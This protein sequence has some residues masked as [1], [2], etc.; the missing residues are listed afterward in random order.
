MLT[1]R[2]TIDDV[3]LCRPRRFSDARGWFMETYSRATHAA[4]GIRT[5][6]I[7]DN[8]SLSKLPFT[9]RGLHFQT[10]PHVQAKLVRVVRGS[11]FDVAVDLRSGSQ[12]Y[13][14][15]CGAT[16]TAEGGEQLFIPAGF[17]H[18]FCTLEPDTEVCYKV[19]GLYAPECDQGLRWDDP[20]LAI[21]WPLEGRTPVLSDKD[22]ALP[23]FA[24]FRLPFSMDILA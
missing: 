23:G 15:W 20:I 13:A 3:I 24:E 4:A 1:E 12:T 7:Q 19:D 17:A 6:F 21:D 9:V 14:R 16:L 10:S 8:Q 5:S 22:S 11:I 2:L 18:G